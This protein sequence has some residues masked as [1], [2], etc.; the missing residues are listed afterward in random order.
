MG[1][2]FGDINN[3]GYLDYYLGTGYQDYDALMP[4]LMFLNDRGAR[5]DDI[6]M[7]G[8]F[9]H[10]QKGHGVSL[11]D[12]DNDGDVDVHIV[13]GGAFPGD[14]FANALFENP[15]FDNHWINIKLRGTTSNRSASAS[16][17]SRTS[18]SGA[19]A[20]AVMP[21]VSGRPSQ[22]QSISAARW[23]SRAGAPLRSATSARRSE[24]L[25]LGAPI[26]SRRSQR[27]AMDL[28]AACRLDVA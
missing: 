1:S 20:P 14:G 27:G 17:T 2:N 28:T 13:M 18:T 7:A 25:L 12:I 24:L 8:G 3:D 4:N 23:I 15:G 26:T 6:S 22:S 11:A 19:E 16:T 9:S 5:F 10:I 21:T